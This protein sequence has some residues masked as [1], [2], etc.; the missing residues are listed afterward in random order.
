MSRRVIASGRSCLECRRRKIRC[1]RSL[2]CAYCTR[3]KLQCRYPSSRSNRD[4]AEDGDLAARVLSVEQA[5]QSLE[6]KITHIGDLLQAIPDLSNR[7]HERIGQGRELSG[8]AAPDLPSPSWSS[9]Q[10]N[11]RQTASQTSAAIRETSSHL[12]QS[13]PLTKLGDASQHEPLALLHPSAAKLPFIW[14]T[15]LDVVDPLIKILHVPSTQRHILSLMQHREVSDAS[16]ECLVFAIYYSSVISLSAVECRCELGEEKQILLERYRQGVERSL[17]QAN[18]WSSRNITVLQAF[19]LYLVCGRQD[20]NGLDVRSLTGLAIGNALKLGLHLDIPGTGVFDREMRRRLW[21]QICTLDVRIVEDYGCEPSILE[22]NL[23]TE[24]PLNVNDA[25]LHPDMGESP[26]PQPGRSE[27]LFSLVRFETSNFTRRILFSDQFCQNNGYHIMDEAQKCQAVDDFRERIEGH[28]L[29]YC[30]TTIPLDCVIVK[31][32]RLVLAKLKLAVC[33]PRVDQNHGMPLR[34]NYRRACED[35]LK[36]AQAL[37]QYD[38]GRRWLWLVQTYVEWD[39]LAYLL[40]DICMTLAS[41]A[42][43]EPINVP[44]DVVDETYDH[45]KNNSD[46]HRDHRWANIEKLRS[47]ALAVKEKVLG[48]IQTRPAT[49]LL[50]QELDHSGHLSD[51]EQQQHG[52]SSNAIDEPATENTVV[53]LPCK[54]TNSNAQNQ[55]SYTAGHQGSGPSILADQYPQI[56]DPGPVSAAPAEEAQ[57]TSTADLPGT[58][59]VCEWSA[60]LIEKYWQVVGHEREDFSLWD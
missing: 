49:S 32:S 58:G 10:S 44:W 46:V 53:D 18:F 41:P 48:A 40:L 24:L 43:S 59:T 2:P 31:S 15:Y 21:W 13:L 45:W 35:V 20:V 38:N 9:R 30:H 55:R 37:R 29:S 22:P 3:I 14:Q 57:G 39:A 19:V 33:K 25:S 16:T 12:L 54:A 11:S 51:V 6:R 42:P 26:N 23:R 36:H 34:A 50:P 8:G 17:T 7:R 52:P 1:D 60:S 5:L 4:A 28:Y 47:N 27:M 56:C